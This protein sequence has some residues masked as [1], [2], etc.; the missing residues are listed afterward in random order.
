MFTHFLT[1]IKWFKIGN[2]VLVNNIILFV[3]EIKFFQ[4]F[5]DDNNINGPNRCCLVVVLKWF[6]TKLTMIIIHS[7]QVLLYPYYHIYHVFIIH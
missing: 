7:Y 1:N 2:W 4:T 6:S 3:I 5:S